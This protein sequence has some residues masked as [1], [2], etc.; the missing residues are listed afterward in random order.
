MELKEGSLKVFFVEKFKL[1][2]F[3]LGWDNPEQYGKDFY[4]FG[5][6][7]WGFV[8]TGSD[9][10]CILTKMFENFLK[11]RGTKLEETKVTSQLAFDGHKEKPRGAVKFI[12]QL[13]KT[14][15]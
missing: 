11:P 4:L 5:T 3:Q 15:L 12:V 8:D 9:N 1:W 2:V 10:L 14:L 13:K 7:M 6:P